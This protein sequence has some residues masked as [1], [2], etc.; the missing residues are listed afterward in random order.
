M[1]LWGSLQKQN[2][3]KTLQEE[4]RKIL[5]GDTEL[6]A[7]TWI[8]ARLGACTPGMSFASINFCFEQSEVPLCDFWCESRGKMHIENLS[9]KI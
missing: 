4:L 8:Y 2:R 9:C 7:G 6:M 5:T 1:V 3:T